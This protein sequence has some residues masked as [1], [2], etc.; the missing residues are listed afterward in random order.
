[1]LRLFEP[2]PLKRLQLHLYTRTIDIYFLIDQ[3]PMDAEND[4]PLF[5]P[6]LIL[7]FG[8]IIAL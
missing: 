2:P 7:Q 1:M 3:A 4:D 8:E 6:A 5:E